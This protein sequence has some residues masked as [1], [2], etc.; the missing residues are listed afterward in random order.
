MAI[1]DKSV[2]LLMKDM[3][4]DKGIKKGDQI[5]TKEVKVWFKDKYP[6]IKSGTV[7]AH[8]RRMS[9]N[10]TSR[11]HYNPI[12]I[13]DDLF[14]QI[15]RSHYR[16]YDKERDHSA[17][18]D[19]D[20]S[21]SAIDDEDLDADQLD[22]TEFAYER[23]LQ[24][25]LRR[26][27]GVI[28][29]GLRLYEEEGITGVEFP[30]GGRFIDILAVDVNDNY[31]VIELKVSRGYDRVVGQLLRYV[32]WIKKNHADPDQAVRGIIIARDISD[33]L[34]LACEGLDGVQ[35]FEYELA[36]TLKEV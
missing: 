12:P 7:S 31:V 2:R 4:A 19:S 20:E 28:E 14:Y 11:H 16:L 9:V 26:N 34:S 18:E 22:Q 10:T 13:E 33:D 35:L 17:P 29:H 24:N 36:I 32:A 15:G 27:L 23:D 6:R 25:F 21:P 5:T 1:Y 30:A 3:V 8:I